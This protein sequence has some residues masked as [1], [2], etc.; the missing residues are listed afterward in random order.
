MEITTND[1]NALSNR[2]KHELTKLIEKLTPK[3][4]EIYSALKDKPFYD[5]AKEDKMDNLSGMFY[6]GDADYYA[7]I[8]EPKFFEHNNRAIYFHCEQ[9]QFILHFIDTEFEDS[10]KNDMMKGIQ[11]TRIYSPL[12]I[13]CIEKS[14]GVSST[15]QWATKLDLCRETFTDETKYSQIVSGG[16]VVVHRP[17]M[18]KYLSQHNEKL[19]PCYYGPIIS[20][21]DRNEGNYDIPAINCVIFAMIA[22]GTKLEINGN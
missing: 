19:N 16:R 10:F 8:I 7:A 21:A 6:A 12:N 4:D 14:W 15:E 13:E 11:V 9:M 18:K 17:T 2:Y 5:P 3:L 1:F 22:I 20:T